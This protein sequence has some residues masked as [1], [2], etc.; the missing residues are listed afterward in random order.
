MEEKNGKLSQSE[1]LKKADQ[2]QDDI[3]RYKF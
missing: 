3:G 2:K 1:R